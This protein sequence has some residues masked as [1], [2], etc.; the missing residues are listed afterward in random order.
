MDQATAPAIALEPVE[1]SQIH[2]IGHNPESNVLAIHFKSKSGP[3][4]IYHYQNF[5]PEQFAAFKSAESIGS[6][7][8]KVIKPF[9]D[10]YP[11]VKVG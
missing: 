1:S 7:F 5:G 10:V 8:G 6:H 4:S 9:P 2:A 3:G 11:Y